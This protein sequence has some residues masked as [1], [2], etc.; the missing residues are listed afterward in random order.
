MIVVVEGIDRVGKTT[1][2]KKL[3]KLGIKTFKD[4][5]V[6]D[7]S[8]ESPEVM[9]KAAHNAMKTA[10]SLVNL[11][12]KDVVIDRFHAS[13]AV[14]G[15]LDRD[16][17]FTGCLNV[18]TSI[19]AMLSSSGDYMFVLVNPVDIEAS[20]Q[21]HGSRLNDHQAMFKEL[22]KIVPEGKKLEVDWYTLDYAVEVIMSE[23]GNQNA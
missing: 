5:S 17:S 10:V 14:Y 20:N 15:L 13:E 11:F 7:E 12:E 16:C 1:L 6:L 2:C 9:Q 22:Y 21:Q 3:E 4:Y 18:F 8:N 19:D 23:I